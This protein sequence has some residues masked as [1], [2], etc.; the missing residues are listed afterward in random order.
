MGQDN[1]QGEPEYI[2]P[3]LWGWVVGIDE[4][5]LDPSNAMGH[6]EENIDRI[7]GS[8]AKHK[9]RKPLVINRATTT[10]EAGNGTWLAAKRLG[11]DYIAVVG[12]EDDPQTAVS[13]AIADNAAASQAWDWE[14]VQKHL[15]SFDE[16]ET[17]VDEAFL[18][19]VREG[20]GV[21]EDEGVGVEDAG[22]QVDRAAELQEKWQCET[23]QV[24]RI[25][26][27]ATPDQ[28]HRLICG[29]CRNPDDLAALLE[30]EKVNGVFTSPPYAMQRAK[31]Y[32][33][34]E[35]DEYVE[36]WEDVQARMR[37]AL[38]EDGSFF[39][40]IKPHC[41]D[42]ERVL[43]VMDL[44]L[45][46]V[47]RWGWRFVDE[48]CWNKPGSPGVFGDR[49]RNDF[50]PVFHFSQD[51]CKFLAKNVLHKT[52]RMPINSVGSNASMQ[53]VV[54]NKLYVR[55]E[56]LARPGNVLKT[57]FDN[58]GML[59][60]PGKFPTSLP[61][62]FILAYS[63]PGDIW[64]DPFCGSGTVGIAAEREGRLSRLVEI[65]P[66]YCAVILERF[67]VEGLKVKSG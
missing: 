51:K 33:G 27:L 49:F 46:M 22:P 39:V 20:L 36:W 31:Q 5:N 29:D 3:D 67:E 15:N 6:D 1:D 13:Y 11:W 50:E 66:K 52:N 53:G 2:I 30:G 8:L 48:L 25:E 26:S 61:S 18:A 23:G 17:V 7:A 54:G 47:R 37:G 55:Q 58:S 62:F 34:V 16:P 19:Q 14:R 12:E 43:Y 45:A 56:G 40:N 60:H 35:V 42:G 24:W 32:G 10:I 4:V 65:L 63:D 44:V 38:G 57:G 21:D 9:Q 28:Y 59:G 41:K 64:L